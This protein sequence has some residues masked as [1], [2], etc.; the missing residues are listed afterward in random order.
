MLFFVTSLATVSMGYLAGIGGK[1]ANIVTIALVLAFSS[2][3]YLIIDLDRPRE[4]FLKVS[5]QPLE[6]LRHKITSSP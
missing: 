3:I 5:Q 2:V 4:G 6:D 1:R